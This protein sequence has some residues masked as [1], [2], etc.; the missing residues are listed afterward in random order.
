MLV[1]WEMQELREILSFKRRGIC[2]RCQNCKRR[3]RYTRRG[4]S[5]RSGDER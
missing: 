5:R 3:E 2:R 4:R 1:E